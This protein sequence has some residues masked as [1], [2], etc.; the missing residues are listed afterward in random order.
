[1][2]S[3]KPETVAVGPG[4]LTTKVGQPTRTSIKLP[5][6]TRL[7]RSAWLG[8]ESAPKDGREI[9]VWREDA[10]C[11]LARW[12]APMD[13]LTDNELDKLD[14]ESAEQYDWFYADFVQGGRLEGEEAPT[15]WMPLPAGPNTGSSAT[16]EKNV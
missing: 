6:A 10:G 8:M 11:L 2:D 15:H 7:V 3:I 16:P 4:R 9:L 14:A 13:F 12:T 5:D 1:M